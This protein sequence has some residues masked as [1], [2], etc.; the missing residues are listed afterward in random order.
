MCGIFGYTGKNNNAVNIVRKGLQRLDYRGYD[1][2]GVAVALDGE[3]SVQK[4]VGVLANAKEINLPKS[5][6]AIGHTRWATNGGVTKNNAHP[7]FS[8][9]KSFVL[10]QNGIVENF[11]Q[12]KNDLASEGYKFTTET[13]TE[14]IV[15]LVE[16]KL[17]SHKDLVSATCQ[18]FLELKGRNTVILLENSGEEILALR[19]G[20]PLV[21]GF[22]KE[23]NDIYLSSDTLSF[24][25]YVDK[26]LVI[27]NG[28]FVRVS[29]GEVGLYSI[30]T[31]KKLDYKLEDLQMQSEEV[32]KGAYPHYMLKEIHESPQVIR[33]VIKLDKSELGRLSQAISKVRNVYTIGSGTA[34]IA[35][36][37]IAYYLR[38][39]GKVRVL[40]LIG[41]EATEYVDLID[42][43]DLIIAPSQSG[44]TAD[45][46]EVL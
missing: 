9:D 3:I 16:K 17:K 12:L 15:R 25:Q 27:E 33:Q 39:I 7:H 41:A 14:V 18:A 26:I 46:L 8:T 34:G 38:K 21:I 36:S 43:Q 32:S 40:S 10:A 28:Q 1:S 20:S 19:N 23:G 22:S 24:A 31:E 2:W 4:D 30:K 11:S 13:D 35:A 5:T 44:E 37:Q 29:M 6:I 45:V 42:K